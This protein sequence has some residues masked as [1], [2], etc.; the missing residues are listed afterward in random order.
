ML[1]KSIKIY[2]KTDWKFIKKIAVKSIQN[3]CKNDPIWAPVE[4]RLELH[5]E[6][7]KSM[8]WGSF[9]GVP[10]ITRKHLK[11]QELE[12]PGLACE[13]EARFKIVTLALLLLFGL[14]LVGICWGR[15]R[16]CYAPALTR[17]LKWKPFQTYRWYRFGA[18]SAAAMLCTYT[19]CH[20]GV[21]KII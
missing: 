17:P 18:C 1:S 11:K 2:S 20:G 4:V 6:V 21:L 16:G 14:A 5:M 13:R 19:F 10:L 9:W 15:S 12:E 3:R 8:V 7:W